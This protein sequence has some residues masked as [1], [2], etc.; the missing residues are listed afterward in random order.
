MN[1][2]DLKSPLDLWKLIGGETHRVPA[3][4]EKLTDSL[5]AT[6]K[7]R[8]TYTFII[9][10]EVA[11]IHFDKAKNEIYFKGHNIRNTNLNP[12]EIKA[13]RDFSDVLRK[14]VRGA[15]FL[16]AYQATLGSRIADNIP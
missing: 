3:T 1:K 14:D 15:E 2:I 8:V 6:Y 9:D 7:D 12:I 13:L 16:K 5:L 4:T 11:S 10:R